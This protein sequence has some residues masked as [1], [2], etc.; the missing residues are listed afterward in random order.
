MNR[1][2]ND[3]YNNLKLGLNSRIH[4]KRTYNKLCARDL[5]DDITIFLTIADIH[6]RAKVVVGKGKNLKSAI[7]SAI[8]LYLSNKPEN[9]TINGV[10]L[11]LVTKITELEKRSSIEIG[12][13]HV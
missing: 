8:N 4:V 2:L 7:S 5:N 6:S 12:R 1:T 10:K 3:I 9:L 11:D 13:A